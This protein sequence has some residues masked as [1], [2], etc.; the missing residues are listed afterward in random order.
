MLWGVLL[1]FLF[2]DLTYLKWVSFV[3]SRVGDGG[4]WSCVLRQKGETV[5]QKA[6]M[7]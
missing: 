3:I 7:M 1:L 4:W 2:S 6:R 5:G